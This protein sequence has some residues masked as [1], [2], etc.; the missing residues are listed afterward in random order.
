[1]KEFRDNVAPG[2]L[3]MPFARMTAPGPKEDKYEG[4]AQPGG[5]A[6][7]EPCGS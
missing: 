2:R 4:S 3:E 1:V 5:L 7:N 6:V